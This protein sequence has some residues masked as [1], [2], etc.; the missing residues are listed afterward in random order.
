MLDGEQERFERTRTYFSSSLEQR[1][2]SQVTS[3]IVL[4]QRTPALGVLERL[5]SHHP[6]L[7]AQVPLITEPH[8]TPT[9]RT[10]FKHRTHFIMSGTAFNSQ[11]GNNARECTPPQHRVHDSNEPLPGSRTA[12][13][14]Y[15]VRHSGENLSGQ[16]IA[17]TVHA[18]GQNACNSERPLDVQPTSEGGHQMLLVSPWLVLSGF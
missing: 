2:C 1:W 13:Q 18:Q 17:L 16:G 4:G 7:K 10:T 8:S 5:K 9:S 14:Q 12:K 11:P 15:E 3:F 6:R